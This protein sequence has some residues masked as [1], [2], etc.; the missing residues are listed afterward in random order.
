MRIPLESQRE[1]IPAA[2][3]QESRAGEKISSDQA[4]NLLTTQR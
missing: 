3:V 2:V 4:I 1:L